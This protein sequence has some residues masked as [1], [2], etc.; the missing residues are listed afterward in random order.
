MVAIVP[1]SVWVTGEI[2]ISLS[3][4]LDLRCRNCSTLKRLLV[5]LADLP[6]YE[7]PVLATMEY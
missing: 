3:F 2:G 1:I 4:Y 6:E 7:Q 5:N